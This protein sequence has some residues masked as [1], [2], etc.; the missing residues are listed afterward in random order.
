MIDRA[1][2]CVTKDLSHVEVWEWRVGSDG[3]GESGVI[4]E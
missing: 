3:G 4:V 1:G 2:G